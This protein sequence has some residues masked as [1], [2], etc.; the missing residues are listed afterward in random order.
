MAAISYPEGLRN[1]IKNGKKRQVGPSFRMA[2]PAG[3]PA[4][5]E[6]FTND[7][8]IIWDFQLTFNN[9]EALVFWSWF[10]SEDHCD[11]GLA[12][13][14]FPLDTEEDS[15]VHEVRFLADGVPQLIEETQNSKTYKCAVRARA[16]VE[17]ADA[18]WLVGY[19]E[20]YGSDLT[21]AE[22]LDIAVNQIWPEA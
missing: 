6:H 16:L 9:F 3:G 20:E 8:P 19:F 18:G 7:Q 2:D 14:D 10:R 11:N 1:A 15:V 21:Q 22:F 4:Y 5:V 13:F 17:A 12:E